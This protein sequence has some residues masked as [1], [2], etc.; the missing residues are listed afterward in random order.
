MATTVFDNM[1]NLRTGNSSPAVPLNRIL[2]ECRDLGSRRLREALREILEKVGADLRQQAETATVPDQ[3]AFLSRLA[4]ALDEKGRRLDAL[5]ADHWVREFDAALRDESADGISGLSLEDMRIVEF[6]EVEEELALKTMAQR[7]REKNGDELYGLGRRLSQVAGKENAGDEDNPAGP[8][9]MVKALQAALRDAE[10]DAKSRLYLCRSLQEPMA[11][12]MPTI[13]G[14]LNAQ[15]VRHNIL[16]DLKRGYSHTP[17]K[18]RKKNDGKGKNA[19]NDMLALM[20]RLAGGESG[21]LAGG[22]SGLSGGGSGPAG[23][24]GGP[25]GAA[26]PV[27]AQVWASL[28]SLQHKD[29]V[30]VPAGAM[31]AGQT[32]VLREFRASP[33]CQD[34][35]TLDVVTVDIVATLFDMIFDDPEIADPIKVL[36]GRLQIPVLKVAMLDKAFFASRSHPARRLLDTISRAALRWGRKMGHE[37]PVYSKIAEIIDRILA[38]FSQ[39]TDLFLSLCE[40]LERF[41]NEHEAEDDAKSDTQ[42]TQAVALVVKREQEELAGLAVDAELQVWLEK[43]LPPV[44]AELLN[45]EWR[46]LLTRILVEHGID[47][48]PWADALKTAQDLVESIRRRR[49]S[50]GRLKLAQQLPI[51]VNQ[52]GKGFDYLGVDADRRHH[53]LDALFSVHSTL[54]RGTESEVVVVST[55]GPSLV[56]TELQFSSKTLANGEVAVDNISL[57][58]PV[59]PPA[60]PEEKEA[61]QRGDWVEF[62]QPDGNAVRY[63]LAWISPERGIYLFTNPQSPRALSVSP[64]AMQLKLQRKEARILSTE[65]IFDRAMTRAVEVLQA[66]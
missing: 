64:E 35:G 60:A 13:Y 24:T 21:G 38:D 61:L 66:A 8:E 25:A 18:E 44:V 53:L 28:D 43:P 7:L 23:G 30:P 58:I 3:R 42:A 41:L 59:P 54:L 65:P 39:D 63:R 12:A 14:D 11:T 55:A 37:D 62:F 57:A 27:P 51:L 50:R 2:A 20:Q 16:P 40:D 5:L 15:L 52:L 46:A 56:D 32:N 10:F 34:L 49:S 29:T 45:R 22:G 6:G 4:Q 33:A 26:G 31:A 48:Q 17:G 1:I 19:G 9:V 36:V 47:S